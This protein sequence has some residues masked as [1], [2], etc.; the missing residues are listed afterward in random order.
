MA[1]RRLGFL[2]MAAACCA[3]QQ[4]GVQ[5]TQTS[6]PVTVPPAAITKLE[7]VGNHAGRLMKLQVDGKVVFEG[8]GHLDPPGVTW[9]LNIQPGSTPAPVELTIEPC[10]APF[11]AELPRNGGV[12]AVIIKGCEVKF[13]RG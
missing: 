7:V 9:T 10:D 1:E 2:A 11:A 6:P 13:A 8:R 12:H 4:A 3:C 5:V